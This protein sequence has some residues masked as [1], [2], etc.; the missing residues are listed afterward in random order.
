MSRSFTVFRLH[1]TFQKIKKCSTRPLKAREKSCMRVMAYI[2]LYVFSAIFI[3]YIGSRTITFSFTS[4][5]GL[6][7][8]RGAKCMWGVPSRGRGNA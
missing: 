5:E 6:P 3:C 8:L 1:I 4:K 7:Q 2:S